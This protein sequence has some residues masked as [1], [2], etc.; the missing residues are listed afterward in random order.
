MADEPIVISGGSVTLDFSDKLKPKSATAGKQKYG[1]DSCKLRTLQVND[2][3][4]R[5]LNENDQITITYDNG[6]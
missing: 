3:P 1:N 5:T 4:P 6:V 2:E